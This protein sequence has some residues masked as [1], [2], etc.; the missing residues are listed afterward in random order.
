MQNNS[1][2]IKISPHNT[3]PKVLLNSEIHE[4]LENFIKAEKG[5]LQPFYE[6]IS[7]DNVVV[8]IHD[9]VIKSD[10]FVFCWCRNSLI[11]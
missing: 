6:E 7:I 5:I 4:F 1:L 2:K 8:G 9:N 3:K 10:E 11:E